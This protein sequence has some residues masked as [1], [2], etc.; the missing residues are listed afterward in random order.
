MD[1]SAV[2]INVTVDDFDSVITFQDEAQWSTP[3]PT[4]NLPFNPSSSPWLYG[5]YHQTGVVNASLTFNF[6]GVQASICLCRCPDIFVFVKGPLCSFME[7]PVLTTAPTKFLLT[8]KALY[9][10]PTL[11]SM[12]QTHTSYLAHPAYRILSIP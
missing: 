3:D 7:P 5:T 9:S 12:L 11:Q 2:N 4:K 6:E 8:V 1:N 10:R